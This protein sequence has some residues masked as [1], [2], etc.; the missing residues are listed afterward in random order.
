MLAAIFPEKLDRFS[1]PQGA[2]AR[3]ADRFVRHE[4]IDWVGVQLRKLA[5]GEPTALLDFNL[6]RKFMDGAI[7]R[8]NCAANRLAIFHNLDQPFATANTFI[9]PRS[10]EHSGIALETTATWGIHGSER[11][12]LRSFRRKGHTGMDFN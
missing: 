10:M 5:Q 9:R 6:E 8:H 1:A 12:C 7:R 4:H 11:D 2:F 3:G